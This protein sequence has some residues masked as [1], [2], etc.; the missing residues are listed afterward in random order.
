MIRSNRGQVLLLFA[1]ILLAALAG[2]AALAIDVGYMLSVRHEL[3]RCADSGALAGASAFIDNTDPVIRAERYASMDK[4]GR[5]LE[6]VPTQLDPLTI[7][8]EIFVLPAADNVRVDTQRMVKLFFASIWQP[9]RPIFA[10]ATARF[11]PPFGPSNPTPD[12]VV[13]LVE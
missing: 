12:C 8:P 9:S 13:R 11:I 4:V 5:G 3:Q 2:I 1:L 6:G 7:P 10:N